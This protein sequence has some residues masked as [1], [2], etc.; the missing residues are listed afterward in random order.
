MAQAEAMNSDHAR[1]FEEWHRA[2]MTRDQDALIA[3]YADDA[4]LETPLAPFIL[5]EQPD[6]VLRGRAAIKHFL[7]EGAKR[8]PNQLV[9]WQRSGRW[10]SS[11]NTLIWEY[12]RETPEGDQIELIEVMEIVN[13]LIQRHHIYWGWFGM[14]QLMNNA[15]AK[16]NEADAAAQKSP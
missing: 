15:M 6:G 7:D 2:A 14:R 5:P 3:L 8:R 1:I 11:D 13:G 10:F 12:P 16:D 9:R 4:V